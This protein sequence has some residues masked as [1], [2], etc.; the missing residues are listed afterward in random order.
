MPAAP[1]PAMARPI[2]NIT[3]ETAA[4]HNME[5]TSKTTKKKRNVHYCVLMSGCCKEGIGNR[6]LYRG[7]A[8]LGFEMGI[9]LAYQRCGAALR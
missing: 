4:P 5:P 7:G 8:N 1:R 9:N 6:Q 3:E 2:I